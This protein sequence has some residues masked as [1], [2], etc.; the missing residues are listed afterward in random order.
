MFFF[1]PRRKHAAKP[2]FAHKRFSQKSLCCLVVQ[3]SKL[4]Y[5][6][7]PPGWHLITVN[8]QVQ[9]SVFT[10]LACPRDN[11]SV[12]PWGGW[13]RGLSLRRANPLWIKGY[14][15]YSQR[16]FK[17]IILHRDKVQGMKF[18]RIFSLTQR[19]QWNLTNHHCPASVLRESFLL[20][21]GCMKI[22]G[23]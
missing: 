18:N 5:Q 1:L 6:G 16:E 13:W 9:P 4:S 11:G 15:C 14:N 23:V 12:V 20:L 10:L 7:Q 22:L 17:N 2:L 8:K 3:K 21:W 19:S